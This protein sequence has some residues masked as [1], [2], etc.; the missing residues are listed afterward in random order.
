MQCSAFPAAEVALA[1]EF[2]TGIVEIVSPSEGQVV[3]ET[4]QITLE[5]T[6]SAAIGL[7]RVDYADALA[8]IGSATA[9]DFAL[10]YSVP[11][12]VTLGGNTL[13]ISVD[14]TTG[15]GDFIRVPSRTIEVLAV[16][17]DADSDG[18]NNGDELAAGSNPFDPDTDGDGL[19][20]GVDPLPT[21]ASLQILSVDPPDGATGVG[22]GTAVVV[23]FSQPLDPAT[24]AASSLQLTDLAGALPA[25]LEVSA[26]GT[27]V[28]LIPEQSLSPGHSYTLRVTPALATS[29]GATLAAPFQSTFQTG[30][31]AI[32]SP[33]DGERVAENST[34]VLEARASLAVGATLSQVVFL[35]DGQ[36]LPTIESALPHSL[37]YR[38]DF[39]VPASAEVSDL[40]IEAIGRDAEGALQASDTIAVSVSGRMRFTPRLVGI[41]P[42][43]AMTL[44]LRVSAPPAIDLS[45]SLSSVTPGVVELPLTTLTLPAGESEIDVAIGGGD[46]G[47]TTLIASSEIGDAGAVVVVSPAIAGVER[48]VHGL[49][50]AAVLEGLMARFALPTGRAL[51]VRVPV[52]SLPASSETAVEAT[53]SDPAVATVTNTPLIASG[54]TESSVALAALSAGSTRI[55]LSAGTEVVSLQVVVHDGGVGIGAVPA[56]PVG[57]ALLANVA[58]RYRVP[59]SGAL[60]LEIPVLTSPATADTPVEVTNSDPLV[61]T[62]VGAPFVPAGGTRAIIRI[63]GVAAGSTHIQLRANGERIT[64]EVIASDTGAGRGPVVAAPT[65]VAL[66]AEG[67]LG[68]AYLDTQLSRSI[69]VSLRP[70]LGAGAVTVEVESP[71]PSVA[72]VSPASFTLDAA[73]TEAIVTLNSGAVEAETLIF[74]RFGDEV[75]SLRVVTGLPPAG[76]EPFIPASPVGVEVEP[77]IGPP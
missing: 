27:R 43:E 20:D 15:D 49:A 31:F 38:A 47:A 63:T 52:L 25:S 56:Q 24:L 60:T 77:A 42:G 4:Q 19:P 66:P 7:S 51:A 55:Q 5:A 35:V 32:V 29:Q 26:G 23:R 64:L 12:L 1:Y 67:T 45:I 68:V 22:L 17:G 65:G 40:A 73:E 34:L 62:V 6:A 76:A 69:R 71:E 70:P 75:R 41:A 2:T 9:P 36:E 61:A 74:F 59:T 57:T 21:I 28:T 16:D 37:S 54:E 48:K 14:A 33:R 44:R 39:A 53:S 8:S 18:L 11:T 3:I 72:S 50:G 13:T 46:E 58:G 30:D 10:A